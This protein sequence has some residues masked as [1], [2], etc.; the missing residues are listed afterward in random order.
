M[1]Y[2]FINKEINSVRNINF[3]YFQILDFYSMYLLFDF[4]F[5]FEI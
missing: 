2:L 1:N 3:I 4:I 5:L